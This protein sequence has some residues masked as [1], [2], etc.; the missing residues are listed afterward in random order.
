MWRP[1]RPLY[2]APMLE[3]FTEEAIADEK[4]KALARKVS[5]AIDPE[6]ADIV[7]ESPSRAGAWRGF[8]R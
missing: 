8:F 2:G 5:V 7:D 3:A 4:I 6:F 1:I